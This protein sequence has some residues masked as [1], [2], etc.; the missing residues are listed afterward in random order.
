MFFNLQM[1]S[2]EQMLFSILVVLYANRELF[3]NRNTK[4]NAFLKNVQMV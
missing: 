3:S 1:Y 2:S 4:K